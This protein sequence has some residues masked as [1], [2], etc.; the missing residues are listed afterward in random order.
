MVVP[1]V[2]VIDWLGQPWVACGLDGLVEEAECEG[3]ESFVIGRASGIEFIVRDG[4]VNTMF[5]YAD[6]AEPD[7]AQ[8]AGR[9]PFGLHFRMGRQEVRA[10]FGTPEQARELSAV[11]PLLG[12]VRPSDRHLKGELFV[13]V[14][15]S[16]T[17]DRIMVVSLWERSRTPHLR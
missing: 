1:A 14:Q 3:D 17:L 15:Y 5:L 2:N 11:D 13:S 4:L 9:L 16:H 12:P 6:G 7:Y 10:L 8:F